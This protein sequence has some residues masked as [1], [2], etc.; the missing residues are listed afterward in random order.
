MDLSTFLNMDLATSM[1]MDPRLQNEALYKD[2]KLH[3]SEDLLRD[4]E[5]L[6]F[7]LRSLGFANH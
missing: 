2:S 6:C 5:V 1:C 4:W 3:F 7:E